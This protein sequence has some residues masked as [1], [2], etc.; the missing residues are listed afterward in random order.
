MPDTSWCKQGGSRGYVTTQ[1]MCWDLLWKGS[2]HT[3]TV[4]PG[5]EFESSV[6]RRLHWLWS[7]DDPLYLRA[8]LFHDVALE[9]GARVFEADML[10]ATVAVS[11][12]API[13]RT[14]IA[15][16]LMLCRR[17]WHWL[18]KRCS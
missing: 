3:L 18:I 16:C 4:D 15:Y 14:A 1:A 13:W 5:R 12:G 6:P 7:P 9:R 8:A 10:W 2:P 11:D 17:S